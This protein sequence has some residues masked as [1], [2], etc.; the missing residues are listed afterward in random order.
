MASKNIKTKKKGLGKTSVVVLAVIIIAALLMG[1]FLLSYTLFVNNTVGKYERQI[2]DIVSEINQ[3]NSTANNI[4]NNNTINP[5]DAK[6]ELPNVLKTLEKAS[7]SLDE[8]IPSNDYKNQN[9]YITEGLKNNILMY[10]QALA[11]FNNPNASDIKNSVTDFNSYKDTCEGQY[12]KFQIGGVTLSVFAGAKDFINVFQSYCDNLVKVNNQ[13]AL[14]ASQYQKYV[15][16]IDDIMSKFTSIKT[17]FSIE[18]GKA[19]SHSITYD[20]VVS[21]ATNDLNACDDLI[22]EA[23]GAVSP[24]SFRDA[25]SNFIKLLNDYDSYLQSFINS[26]NNEKVQAGSS[27]APLSDAALKDIY[28]SPSNM[29]I[30]ISDNYSDFVKK[31]TDLKNNH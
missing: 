8:N 17:D 7:S 25:N 9:N 11:I 18:L 21:L 6:K 4:V 27:T 16:T 2:K 26:V 29:F 15:D 31:Y 3:A 19:R 20:D 5:Q 24:S 1:T 12:S 23:K 10:R 28:F 22:N 30:S 14:D 13:A